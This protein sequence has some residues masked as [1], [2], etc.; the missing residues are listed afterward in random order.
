MQKMGRVW[1]GAGALAFAM[2]FG[3]P[4]FAADASDPW[5]TTKVKASL[6]TAESVDGL[7]INVDTLDGRVTLHGKAATAAEKAQ[8]E[9]LAKSIEGVKDV[10]NLIEVVPASVASAVAAKDE[11]VE[12]RVKEALMGDSTLAGSSIQVQS[13][14]DG[15][16]LLDGTA[17]SLSAHLQALETARAVDGVKRVESQIQSPDRLADEEIWNDAPKNTTESAGTQVSAA[18]SDAWITSA[19]KVRLMAADVSAFDVNVDTRGGV[20]TLFGA[21]PSAAAKTTA[22]AEAKKVDGVKS[23][24]NELQVVPESKAAAVEKK[25]DQIQTAVTERLGE[26]TGL[27]DVDV[28]VKNGV[29]RLTGSVGSQSDRLAALTTARTSEGVRSVVGDGLRVERN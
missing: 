6:L 10:R 1:L 29:V 23:V 18:A 12:K 20:V 15:A 24:K 26:K 5:I 25:D 28:E 17:E 4:A 27:K 8:A 21:V 13:V 9:K 11:D 2:T 3:T 7:K 22:E 19:T 16:V 14:N